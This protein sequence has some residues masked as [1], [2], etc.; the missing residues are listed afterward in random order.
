M[1]DKRNND[2]HKTLEIL[3]G[4]MA[5]KDVQ[6]NND[7]DFD[8]FQHVSL[9]VEDHIKDCRDIA[10]RTGLPDR[11]ESIRL[12]HDIMTDFWGL[13]GLHMEEE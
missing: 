9:H 8:I 3:L 5:G 11:L 13:Y 4:G 12:V 10:M 1:D 2:R 7:D 6:K